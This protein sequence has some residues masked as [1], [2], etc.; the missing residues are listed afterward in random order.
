[1]GFQHDLEQA[2]GLRNVQFTTN[3][4][5][6]ELFHEA[7][8]SDRG[9]IRPDGSDDEPKALATKLGVKGPLVFY[10]DPDRAPVGRSRTPSASPGRRSKR[11]CGG[12]P[13][14]RSSTRPSTRPCSSGSRSTSNAEARALY[15][16]DVFAATDP[17]YAVPYRF[18]GEY[19][20]HALFAHN[21][22]P[23]NVRGVVNEDAK[24]WTMLNVPSFRCVTRARR[25]RAPSAPSSSTS[26]TG[27]AS[28]RV[29]RTTAG[30]S[31][32]RCSR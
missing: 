7:L 20:T 6:E 32:R 23:K 14:S 8:R 9:R 26:R 24:R 15:V 10:T 28:C 11:R 19:A 2:F 12:R 5:K 21:M 1:M 17:E 29:A 30:W 22:F 25:R 31:R 3:L 4:S 16:K 18:V 13:T 27:S